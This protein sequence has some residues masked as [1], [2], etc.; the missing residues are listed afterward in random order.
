MPASETS[1]THIPDIRLCRRE[2]YQRPPYD[3]NNLTREADGGIVIQ[4]TLSGSVSFT[5]KNKNRPATEVG[6]AQA[7]LFKHGEDS[8]YGL[9]PRSRCPYV[10]EFVVFDGAGGAEA[11]F[12]GIR[13]G[14]G[15]IIPM[16]E[17]GEAALILQGLTSGFRERQIH[18]RLTLA[19]NLY[20]LLLAIQRE[21]MQETRGNDPVAYGRHLLETQFRSPRNLKEWC[22][23][24]GLSRE[25]FS[26]GFRAR[27]GE[28][29]AQFLRLQR[30]NH[31]RTLVGTSR[32]SLEDVA[33]ASGFASVQTFHRAYKRAFGKS[34]RSS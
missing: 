11:L 6:R 33:N 5:P 25:H 15:E 7:M 24:I 18:D 2:V 10:A 28:S 1:L 34:A 26:R 12:D 14:H 3:W 22:E 27:Y 21:Q 29:P 16:S 9:S 23:E 32:M 8:R 30:L 4:R 20:R 19:E 31:A 13:T 17:Q